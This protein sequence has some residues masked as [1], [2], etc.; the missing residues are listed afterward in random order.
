[1]TR[2]VFIRHGETEAVGKT[3]TGR[4]PGVRL[5][6]RGF[7]QVRTLAGQLKFQRLDRLVTSPMERARQTA[8]A[9]TE[10]HGTAMEIDEALLE[11]D[12]GEWGGCSFAE[13]EDDPLWRR[14]HEFRGGIRIPGGEMA[15]EIQA[16]VVAATERL[17]R[18]TPDGVIA[19]V[20]H[21]DPIRYG[22]AFYAGI[23]LDLALRTNIDIASVS[24]I[25]VDDRGAR[26]LCV[27]H[28]GSLPVF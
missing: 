13:M 21:G 2:F 3:L 15:L 1:M 7:D 22:V 10:V 9:I 20:S 8:A 5:T 28:T 25:A 26:V 6:E 18:E 17:R 16:R 27:N 12:F 24:A 11:V 4:A 19:L 23:P 14:Y